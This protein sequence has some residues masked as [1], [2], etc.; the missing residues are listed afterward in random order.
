MKFLIFLSLAGFIMNAYADSSLS[1]EQIDRWVTNRAFARHLAD[2]IENH[3]KR[4]D[5][6]FPSDTVEELNQLLKGLKRMLSFL[7]SE[8]FIDRLL[9]FGSDRDQRKQ[10]FLLRR[11][12]KELKQ[13][14]RTLKSRSCRKALSI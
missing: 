6:E 10:V 14:R 11:Q 7:S 4:F 12:I 3:P 9:L 13:K 8:I 5:K 1:P 2:L